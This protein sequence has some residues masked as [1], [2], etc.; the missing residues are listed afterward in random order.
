MKH[1]ALRV[2]NDNN[3]NKIVELAEKEQRSI[4]GQINLLL[5]E[6]LTNRK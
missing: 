1:F 2:K 3:Y 4:N 6:A 5:T